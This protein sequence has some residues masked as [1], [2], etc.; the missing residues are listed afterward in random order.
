MLS[1]RITLS[2]NELALIYRCL[3][4]GPT[5]D[6]GQAALTYRLRALLNAKPTSVPLSSLPAPLLAAGAAPS[7][8]A[9]SGTMTIKNEDLAPGV[10]AAITGQSDAQRYAEGLTKMTAESWVGNLPPY[11]FEAL[12]PGRVYTKIVS[13][14]GSVHAFVDNL[15]QVYKAES[16][17]KPAKGVRFAT[18]EQALAAAGLNARLAFAGGYLYADRIKNKE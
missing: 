1:A 9:I 17:N 5:R 14:Q 16:F 3:A 6:P 8:G 15:G 4:T 18:V 13:S 7:F 10:L 2:A 11:T 12:K